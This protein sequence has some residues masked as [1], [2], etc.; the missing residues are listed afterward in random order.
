[1]NLL[2]LLDCLLVPQFLC[3]DLDEGTLYVELHLLQ[4]N[5]LFHR[6]EVLDVFAC[7]DRVQ[8]LK[9]VEHPHR[10]LPPLLI[11][12]QSNVV[13]SRI[14]LYSRLQ[15]NNSEYAIVIIIDVHLIFLLLLQS[16][17]SLEYVRSDFV[18]MEGG[19][20]EA[21]V[22]VILSHALM[23]ISDHRRVCWRMALFHVRDCQL[24]IPLVLFILAQFIAHLA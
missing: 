17:V 10:H 7:W 12:P 19:L 1:M 20:V 18:L 8:L 24:N 14:Q 11:V 3:V 9:D 13:L 22:L 23:N 15:V 16:N 6:L 21:E 5:H 4:K 2:A